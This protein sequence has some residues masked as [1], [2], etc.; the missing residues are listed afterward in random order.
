LTTPIRGL[1]KTKFGTHIVEEG[2]KRLIAER[3]HPE[4][5]S[6]ISPEL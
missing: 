6:G 1:S 5:F 4:W 3:V 2:G